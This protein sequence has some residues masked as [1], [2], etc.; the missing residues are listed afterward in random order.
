MASTFSVIRGISK[1]RSFLPRDYLSI[2]V[3]ALTLSKLDYCNALY[4]GINKNDLGLLQSAQNAA[5]R[6]IKGGHKFDRRS[7]TP[8]YKELHWLR[9]EERVIFKILLIVHKCVWN[10]GPESYRDMIKLSNER[11]LNW[12]KRSFLQNTG[13]VHSLAQVQNYGT[14]YL[15]P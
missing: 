10:M 12:Q 4:Y 11:T 13:D 14:H 1:I 9:I 3:C 7:L 6:L 15:W 8:I 5:I 2:L